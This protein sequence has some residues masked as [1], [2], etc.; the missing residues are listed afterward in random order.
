MALTR[1]FSRR[2]AMAVG[3][4]T[5]LAA[6]AMSARAASPP[7]PH[8]LDLSTPKAQ[9]TAFMKLYASLKAETVFYWYSGMIDLA[10]PGQPIIPLVAVDTLIRRKVEP[11]PDGGFHVVTW[12]ADIYH[13]K[14]ETTP[15]MTM[16]NPVNDRMVEPFHIREGALT[17]VYS[18]TSF[19]M[20]WR[21]AGDTIWTSREVYLDLPNALDPAVW[22]LESAGPREQFAL[23]A[24]HTGKASELADPD[25]ACASSDFTFQCMMGW[26]P[27]LLMG[28]RP[29]HQLWRATGLKLPSIEDLPAPVRVMFEQV[30]PRI[31]D[32]TPWT[33]NAMPA[34]EFMKLRKP[35]I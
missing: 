4:A 33:D 18:D 28:Q 27:W 13:A 3:L 29:G 35:A 31:F 17:Y 1:F 26:H 23:I 11:Q 7:T 10:L 2:Q 22:R 6:S 15:L 12:E 16:R 24:T 21:R 34:T 5:P 25:I 32:E 19:N 8:I 14:G 9:L 20:D 30:H